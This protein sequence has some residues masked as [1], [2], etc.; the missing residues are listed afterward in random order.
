[1]PVFVGTGV[2]YFL[3]SCISCFFGHIF[4]HEVDNHD[5]SGGGEVG[6]GG[7]APGGKVPALE[8]KFD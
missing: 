3:R 1:M 7:D 6:F 5:R 8:I 2:Y 4:F